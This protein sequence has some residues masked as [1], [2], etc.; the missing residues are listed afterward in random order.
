[1]KKNINIFCEP[2][3]KILINTVSLARTLRLKNRSD[4]KIKINMNKDIKHKFT[5]NQDIK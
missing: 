5:L 2:K 4:I 1:M 3:N